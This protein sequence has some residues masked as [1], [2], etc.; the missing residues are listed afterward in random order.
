MG[1]AGVAVA[2]LGGSDAGIRDRRDNPGGDEGLNR[3]LVSHF[4]PPA[5]PLHLYS[6]YTRP[7]GD[8]LET[9]SRHRQGDTDLSGR[10]LYVLINRGT[11]S[12]AENISFTLQGLGLATLIGEPS[13]GGG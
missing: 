13:A 5:R 11:A 7:S 2:C 8:T 3:Y 4:V 6:R 10:P 9:W 12:A 1:E